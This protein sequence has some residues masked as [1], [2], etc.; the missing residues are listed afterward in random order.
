[1]DESVGFLFVSIRTFIS[2]TYDARHTLVR[3][4]ILVHMRKSTTVYR[5]IYVSLLSTIS[6]YWINSPHDQQRSPRSSEC[7]HK[8][9]SA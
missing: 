9:S 1:M 4:Y 8:V 7:R 3:V 6:L 2:L 5:H